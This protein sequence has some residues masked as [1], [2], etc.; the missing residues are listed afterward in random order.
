[1]FWT[2]KRGQQRTLVLTGASRRHYEAWS[3]LFAVSGFLFLEKHFYSALWILSFPPCSHYFSPRV[4]CY[5]LILSALVLQRLNDSFLSV[6][7]EFDSHGE[8]LR[9]NPS[10][11]SSIQGWSSE[12]R[13]SHSFTSGTSEPH[14]PHSVVLKLILG[15][16]KSV[17]FFSSV[18]LFLG[19]VLLVHFSLSQ[20][21]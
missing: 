3:H 10:S 17:L 15:P 14:V 20:V 11:M 13:R 8:S 1:M 21:S 19:C 12:K 18:L 4:L 7:D 16:M 5:S 6:E 9:Q 2:S